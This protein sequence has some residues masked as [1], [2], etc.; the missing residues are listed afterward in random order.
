[1]KWLPFAIL[2]V[3]AIVCQT[4]ILP[5]TAI[6]AIWPEWTFVLAMHYALW[7]PWPGAAIAAWLLGL[8][9]DLQSAPPDPVFL[10]AFCYGAAAWVILRVRGLLVPNHP[11]TQALAT[12]VLAFGVQ[13]LVSGYR[14]WKWPD[15]AAGEYFWGT[16]FFTALY[17]AAWAPILHWPLIRLN[18]WAG[19]RSSRR[20]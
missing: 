14:A 7:G 16:A 6:R 5:L 8:V 18:R 19:L 3:A 1:M 12:L 20:F 4:T 2:G 15:S 13:L 11:M 10:H 9:V 17:T